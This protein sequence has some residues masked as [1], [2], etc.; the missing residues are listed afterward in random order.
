MCAIYMLL[1]SSAH[2]LSTGKHAMSQIGSKWIDLEK[3]AS[4]IEELQ[5]TRMTDDQSVMWHWDLASRN[6]MIRRLSSNI[7]SSQEWKS[8]RPLHPLLIT[9]QVNGM[10]RSLLAALPGLN[11]CTVWTSST[12]VAAIAKYDDSLVPWLTLTQKY[13]S[14]RNLVRI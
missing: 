2:F 12:R 13:Q 3:N 7:R 5:R 10:I 1:S 6:I 8:E 4:E 11:T 14:T 9:I